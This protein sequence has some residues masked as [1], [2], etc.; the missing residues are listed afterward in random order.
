MRRFGFR[1]RAGYAAPLAPLAAL[2]LSTPFLFCGGCPEPESQFDP[3]AVAVRST[4]SDFV[5][6]VDPSRDFEVLPELAQVLNSTW[7][8]PGNMITLAE[9]S[10]SLGR[11]IRANGQPIT[12]NQ[13]VALIRETY[14]RIDGAPL[15][16]RDRVV[17]HIVARA[18]GAAVTGSTEITTAE[19]LYLSIIFAA[20]VAQDA[21]FEP[22]N[23]KLLDAAAANS[24]ANF[25]RD[26]AW[27]TAWVSGSVLGLTYVAILAGAVAIGPVALTAIGAAAAGTL[28]VSFLVY[29]TSDVFEDLGSYTASRLTGAFVS[30][31]RAGVL[32]RSEVFQPSVVADRDD[33]GV[34][35]NRDGCPDDPNKT[36][37]GNCGCGR[38]EQPGCGQAA[39]SDGDGTPDARDGCPNDPNK[40]T[41]GSCGCGQAESAGCGAPA[42]GLVARYP[43]DGNCNDVSGHGFHGTVQGAALTAGRSGQ[44]YSFDSTPDLIRLPAEVLNGANDFTFFCVAK[45]APLGGSRYP[46]LISGASASN[47]NEL[48][49]EIDPSGFVV[50][51]I[52]GIAQASS[53]RVSSGVWVSLTWVRHGGAG[54]CEIYIDGA[55]PATVTGV[56]AGALSIVSNGLWIGNDQDTVGGGWEDNGQFRGAID[57]V[58]IFNRALTSHE[59][60]Q[61][62]AAN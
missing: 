13:V 56:G 44:A 47:T 42:A 29:A 9:F 27:G 17:A 12:T 5:A 30:P 55:S 26:W 31:G 24:W 8:S 53:A 21:G 50:P 1:V 59:V 36:S 39:D 19:A 18:G 11:S 49:L 3:R 46:S 60:A 15:T 6:Y 58:S 37:P 62:H 14:E 38:A 23:A 20:T 48:L 33:D 4:A 43:M 10:Q 51:R 16:P 2:V 28:A 32:P 57:E 7:N 41:P 22:S 45:F 52:H 25:Q 34:P 61:L 54:R 40:L 35:D